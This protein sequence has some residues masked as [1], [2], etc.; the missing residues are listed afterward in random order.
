MWSWRDVFRAFV[1]KAFRRRTWL[2]NFSGGATPA[3][4]QADDGLACGTDLKVPCIFG[5]TGCPVNAIL[6][7][8]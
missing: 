1:P 6:T 8:A 5:C 2:T 3:E 4:M 7:S